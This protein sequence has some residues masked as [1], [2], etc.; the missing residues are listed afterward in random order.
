MNLPFTIETQELETLFGKFGKIEEIE[1][2][3]KYG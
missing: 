3:V 1:L 2:P